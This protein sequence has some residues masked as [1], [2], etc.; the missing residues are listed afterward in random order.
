[1]STD[2]RGNGRDHA[3]QQN[4]GDNSNNNNT[5]ANRSNVSPNGQFDGPRL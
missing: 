2:N 1:M 4:L 3:K 5:E